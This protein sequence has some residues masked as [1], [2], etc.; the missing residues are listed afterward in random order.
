MRADFPDKARKSLRTA[1]GYTKIYTLNTLRRTLM[2]GRYS[3]I[4][5][6]QQKLRR[7]LRALGNETF[8]ALQKGEVNPLLTDA[9]KDA[10]A[11]AKAI[12]AEKDRHYQ[13]IAGLREKIANACACEFP[14]ATPP[15]GEAPPEEPKV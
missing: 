3:I 4:C 8:Q 15:P 12:K 10:L 9:V 11:R 2:L 6:Q 13:A 14:A 1:W 5:W 7:A